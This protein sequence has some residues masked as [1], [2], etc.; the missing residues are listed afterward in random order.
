MVFEYSVSIDY[1][2]YRFLCAYDYVL[3]KD[4]K[5]ID[6]GER[7]ITEYMKDNKLAIGD[8]GI[9]LLRLFGELNL[10]YLPN[11]IEGFKVLV[12]GKYAFAPKQK[13]IDIDDYDTDLSLISGDIL[14]ELYL[15][16]N[17]VKIESFALYNCRSL[18]FMEMSKDLN[19]VD[20]DAFMNCNKL[21][22][23]NLKAEIKDATGIRNVLAQ[24][25]QGLLVT[26]K[27]PDKEPDK[28]ETSNKSE[29]AN[30]LETTNKLENVLARF[31]FPEYSESYEEIGP[32]HIFAFNVDGEGYRAR[33]QF[34]NGVLIINGYD[35]TFSKAVSVEAVNTLAL[36]A[37][38]RLLYPVDLSKANKEMYYD[39]IADNKAEILKEVI[40]KQDMESLEFL[41]KM[42]I[43]N[44]EDKMLALREATKCQWL[45]A[46]AKII[47]FRGE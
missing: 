41:L 39:F 4:L 47:N 18:K 25:K 42:D 9:R 31:Y 5:P 15:N 14:E 26:F 3:T 45:E 17:L 19:L 8:V 29:N 44:N 6:L 36:M 12:L 46:S 43:I 22:K 2:D 30:I 16:E 24:Y 23:I 27:E 34:S 13:L 37:I 11:E 28:L 33:Q 7:T 20:G 32:A 21:S 1:Y 10:V 35:E 38:Y 40:R